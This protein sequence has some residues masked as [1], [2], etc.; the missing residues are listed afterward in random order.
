M[1]SSIH[2]PCLSRRNQQR[3][4]K[5]RE[6]ARLRFG[7]AVSWATIRLV[8]GNTHCLSN[9]SCKLDFVAQALRYLC[10]DAWSQM[11]SLLLTINTLILSDIIFYIASIQSRWSIT[12]MLV[13]GVTG[14]KGR[15]SAS[16][17]GVL[18][19]SSPGFDFDWNLCRKQWRYLQERGLQW[20]DKEVQKAFWRAPFS[21]GNS[22]YDFT[23]RF[24]LQ[25]HG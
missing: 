3:V 14:R 25:V 20:V 5:R 24:L 22:I 17:N 6:K 9:T 7:A 4:G 10:K 12:S 16:S 19:T 23:G 8:S 18:S 2:R 13:R 21:W 1:L 15:F 11:F